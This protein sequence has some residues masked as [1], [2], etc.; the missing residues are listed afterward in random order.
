MSTPTPVSR[1]ATDRYLRIEREVAIA[2]ARAL[3]E[4]TVHQLV[5]AAAPGHVDHDQALD[6]LADLVAEVKSQ[7]G[8]P[9]V[10]AIKSAFR[11]LH[12]SRLAREAAGR[13]VAS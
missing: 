9:D 11:T 12:K 4:V 7:C 8:A 5:A 1:P 6:E 2:D 13:A 3:L 10:T